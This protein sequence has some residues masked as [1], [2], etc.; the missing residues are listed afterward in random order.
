MT[1][2]AA[3]VLKFLIDVTTALAENAH[4]KFEKLNLNFLLK[5]FTDFLK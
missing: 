2:K 5:V 3:T 1:Q 4:L